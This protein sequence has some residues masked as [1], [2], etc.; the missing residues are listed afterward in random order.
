MKFNPEL[1][2][3][4]VSRYILLVIRGLESSSG[5]LSSNHTHTIGSDTSVTFIETHQGVYEYISKPLDQWNAEKYCE[6]KFASLL[7]EE[8]GSLK[9]TQN[10]L[11]SNLVQFP[12]WLKKANS[13]SS[14][15]FP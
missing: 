1:H 15:K 12:I 3:W 13:S 4:S 10:L 5:V 7:S 9:V 6:H 2:W 8:N 14:R 11:Q